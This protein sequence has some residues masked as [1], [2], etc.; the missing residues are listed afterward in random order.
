MAPAQM[1]IAAWPGLFFAVAR[2]GVGN[3]HYNSR[4]DEQEEQNAQAPRM[5]MRGTVG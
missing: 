4:R 1:V 5:K 3:G 2:A